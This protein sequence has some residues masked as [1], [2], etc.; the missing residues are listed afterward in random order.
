M[1]KHTQPRTIDQFLNDNGAKP[2]INKKLPDGVV[3]IGDLIK[4]FFQNTQQIKKAKNH[5]THNF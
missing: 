3:I 2:V 4:V 5:V 1:T